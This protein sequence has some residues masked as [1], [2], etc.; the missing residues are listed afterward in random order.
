[1]EGVRLTLSGQWVERVRLTP[2]GQRSGS[3]PSVFARRAFLPYGMWRCEDGREVLFNRYY[4]PIHERRAGGPVQPANPKE[5]VSRIAVEMWF[6][7]DGTKQKT[8]VGKEKLAAFMAGAAMKGKTYPSATPPR[9]G[10]PYYGW[11]TPTAGW[12][13]GIRPLFDF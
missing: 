4:E 8:R 11:Q 6:Y 2:A 7:D 9:N 10:R 5:W 12:P 3:P 1:M 13:D